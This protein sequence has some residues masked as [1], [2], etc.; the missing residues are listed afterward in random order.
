[1]IEKFKDSKYYQDVFN[2]FSVC[3]ILESNF[4]FECSD[5]NIFTFG[6]HHQDV[7]HEVNFKT[8]DTVMS[9][10]TGLE[11]INLKRISFFNHRVFLLEEDGKKSVAGQIKWTQPLAI[12]N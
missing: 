12:S 9:E 3:N 10:M 5:S 11:L 1:M 7:Y 2:E 8:D 6:L 4:N